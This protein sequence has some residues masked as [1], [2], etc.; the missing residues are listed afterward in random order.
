MRLSSS[1]VGS[2]FATHRFRPTPLPT[3]AMVALV[4][5]ALALGNWQ[6]HRAGEKSDA[7]A[8]AVAA[9]R[10]APLELAAAGGDAAAELYRRVH[11]TG[12]YDTSHAVMIDN[13]VHNGQPG[14]EVVMPFKLTPGGSYVLVNRG[15]VAQ[16]RTRRDPPAV[17]TP[18]GRV[19]IIGRA[20]IPS[21]RYLELKIDAEEGSLR[22]NLDIERIAVSSGL[23]LLPFV[24]EQA[25]PVIPEDDLIRD[26]PKP[27]FGI[28]RHLSYMV[29][30]Y[31]LAGLA[32]VLWLVLNWKPL[33]REHRGG[34]TEAIKDDAAS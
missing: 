25:D 17:Q 33:A 11:G 27:D 10:Q 14:Y 23:S 18:S 12:E 8:L 2:F 26:W 30:W 3:V 34:T 19:E 9:E 15:W 28:E 31:S 32:L 21:K 7:A 29:Q 5:L 13:K 20:T 1:S 4:A 22:Q 24:V 16:G 6:R